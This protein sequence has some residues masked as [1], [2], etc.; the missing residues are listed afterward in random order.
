MKSLKVITL[1]AVLFSSTAYSALNSGY[2]KKL[3]VDP[4]NIVIVLNDASGTAVNGECGSNYYH[5]N[6]TADNFD[7]FYALVLTAA[8]SQKE[9]HLEVG[10]CVGNRNILTHGS[11][12]F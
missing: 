5:I 1:I 9:V 3:Y 10:S 6:R 12:N 7:E 2:V 11:V 4:T 8:A